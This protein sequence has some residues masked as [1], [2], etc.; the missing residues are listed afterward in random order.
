M[1]N[2]DTL[3]PPL[4]NGKRRKEKKKI[5]CLKELVLYQYHIIEFVKVYA[6]MPKNVRSSLSKVR[7]YEVRYPTE[8][9]ATVRGEL[10]CTL[11]STIVSHD[12]KFSVDKYCQS[13][14]HHKALL[15]STSQQRQQPLGIPTASFDWNDYVGKVTAAFL[16]ADI[17]LY[18]LNNADLQALFKCVG[19]KAP[20]KSACR[21]QIDNMGK[22]E[23][24]RICNILSD[25]VIFMIIDEADISGSKYVNTLVGD[26]EQL[27]KTYLLH[28][29]IL[30]APPNQQTVVHALDDAIRTLQTDRYNFVLLLTDAARY[31]TTS[32]RVAKQTYPR[33][34]RITSVVHGLHNAAARIRANYEDVDKLIAAVKALVVKNKD[35]RAKFSTIN[36]P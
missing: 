23:V 24:N 15:S 3:W 6:R 36:S 17:T 29:K 35:R 20:F 7:A 16:S 22:C 27:E 5:Y 10:L 4:T 8:F 14:K 33:L 31:M 34:F 28:C 1:E 18:K 32:G 12:R 2:D 30:D 13:T 26:V 9:M 25:K 21:K 11:C 19:Q